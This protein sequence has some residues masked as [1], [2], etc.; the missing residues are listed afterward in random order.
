MQLATPIR[1][2][3]LHV[4]EA[5]G[6]FGSGQQLY[7]FRKPDAE[8]MIP[9]DIN[10]DNRIDEN[11]FTSY[12]NYTGLRQGDG[13]FEGYISRGDLNQ[14][15]LIDAYDISTVGI[16]LESGVS[17]KRVPA[18]AGTV[19]VTADKKQVNAG[20]IVTLTVKGKGLVSVN[21]LS[22]AIPYD[23]TLWEYVGI[24]AAGM[25]EM[26]NLTYDR[27]HTS[28][29]KALYPT[30]VNCGEHPYLEGDTDL[31]TIRFRAKQKGKVNLTSQDGMILD[32]YLNVINW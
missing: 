1:Y 6:G 32:K 15:G 30:F 29:Q 4:D 18:V 20:D 14:N 25:K 13:D 22:F 7:V 11:D 17:S 10:H 27:L 21:A 9:G 5:R 8:M 31:L 19:S 3:R 12:M 28:G 2:L 16:E 26:R 23:A 24:D